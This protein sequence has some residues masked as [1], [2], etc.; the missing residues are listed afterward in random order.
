MPFDTQ[1]SLKGR[2]HVSMTKFGKAGK[3]GCSG[4]LFRTV[5][6]WQFRNIK[7]TGAKLEELKIQGILKQGEG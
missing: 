6:L 2:G 4:F 5:R 3:I 7:K 1:A